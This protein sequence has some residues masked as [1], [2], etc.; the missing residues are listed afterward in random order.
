MRT[1]VFL[2]TLFI[3]S[4]QAMAQTNPYWQWLG[5]PDSE[6]VDQV[7]ASGDTIYAGG[8]AH[9]W[10]TFNGGKNWEILDSAAGTGSILSLSVGANHSSLIYMSKSSWVHTI[11]GVLYKSTDAGKTWTLLTDTTT[12]NAPPLSQPY[13]G[14]RKVYIS[15]YDTSIVF[16]DVSVGVLSYDELYRSTDGGTS[17]ILVSNNFNAMDHGLSTEFAFDPSDSTKMYATG[18]D[19]YN[20]WF[21][22]STDGGIN[23]SNRSI[24]TVPHIEFLAGDTAWDVIA[25]RGGVNTSTDGGYTWGGPSYTYQNFR[26]VNMQHAPTSPTAFYCAAYH[27]D[28]LGAPLQYGIYKSTDTLR[29][30]TLL[31]GSENLPIDTFAVESNLKVFIDGTTGLLYV[32]STK[33]LYRYYKSVTS[34]Q[35]L[36]H[37][38]SQFKLYPN[39]PNPF[40]PTTTISY[41]LPKRVY[42]QLIV[43]SEL[44]QQVRKLVNGEQVAGSY[45]VIFNGDGLASGAYFYVLR[46][47]TTV[48]YGKAL[49]LK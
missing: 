25:Y 44:G 21:Y 7:Y 43:Y 35:T 29:S 41:T 8:P 20:V 36:S 49:L 30:W 1:T 10:S 40:N 9:L 38:P 11:W 22:A 13:S 48:L 17:W 28:S 3:L 42:V 15:P 31:N 32:T 33:G 4:L 16:A 23:W 26:V 6:E 19:D 5:P 34:A 18:D 45:S 47:G 37:V 24:C 39:Y 46:A 12:N 27:Y 14:L 2:T